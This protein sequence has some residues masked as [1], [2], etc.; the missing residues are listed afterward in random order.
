M[1]A[2]DIEF[3][4]GNLGGFQR[5]IDALKENNIEE[6][7]QESRT[8]ETIEGVKQE[9]TSGNEFRRKFLNFFKK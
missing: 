1:I 9:L 8:Y 4:V 2:A 5:F 3:N 6:M 7:I